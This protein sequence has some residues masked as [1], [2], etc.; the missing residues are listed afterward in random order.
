V[1]RAAP[2]VVLLTLGALA[3]GAEVPRAPDRWVT[4]GAGLLTASTRERLDQQ[5]ADYQR[6]T[7]HQVLVWIGDSSGEASIE[8]FAARAFE[9]WKVGRAGLDDGLVVFVLAKDR[10]AR[11]EVGYGLEPVVPDAVASR[12]LREHLLPGLKAGQADEAV[13]SSVAALLASIEGGAAPGGPAVLPALPPVAQLVVFGVLALGF[14]V[15]LIVRPRL[16]LQL[17]FIISA[18]GRGRGRG[19]GGGFG[20]SGGGGRSGGGGAS[21]SW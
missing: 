6:R 2:W 5:L 13:S 12:V 19:S 11:I 21:G 10:R 3:W 18:A 15:L 8:E 4:D 9:A 16:A 20:F 7:G 17:L 1:A 14:L